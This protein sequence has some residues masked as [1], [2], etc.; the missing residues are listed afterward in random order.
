MRRSVV[1]LATAALVASAF[2]FA[3][4]VTSQQAETTHQVTFTEDGS[5][6]VV[7]GPPGGINLTGLI[8]G[9]VRCSSDPDAYCET[10]LVTVEQ[11]VADEDPD[12]VEFGLGQ[13]TIDVTSAVPGGDFDLYVRESD[14]DGSRGTEMASSGNASACAQ[15]CGSGVPDPIGLWPNQ[16]DG[17][18]ECVDVGVTTTDVVGTKYLLVEIVYFA[19]PAGYTANLSYTRTDGR[20]FDGTTPGATPT[21][22][23]DAEPAPET[24]PS[25]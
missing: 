11:P 19:A 20:N 1:F 17:T 4:A 14:A 23:P 2:A 15:V 8:E 6:T 3:P 18:D 12:A 21:D 13:V 24:E 10:I 9:Q 22:G 5:E 25:P 16:C 7:G